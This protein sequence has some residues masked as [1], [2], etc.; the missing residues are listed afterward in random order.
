VSL[1]VDDCIRANSPEEL[2]ANINLSVKVGDLWAINVYN[3]HRT[4]RINTSALVLDIAIS[5]V[6]GW[7]NMYV[8]T[9]QYWDMVQ[10]L[11]H[12]MSYKNF[13]GKGH[14][15]MCRA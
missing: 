11:K 3:T 6:E 15:R 7:P 14:W 5:G 8:V 1:Q 10:Q 2:E 9:I 12:W 13:M 4:A